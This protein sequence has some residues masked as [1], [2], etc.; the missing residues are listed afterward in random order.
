MPIIRSAKKR[1][2]QEKKRA[3]INKT[4]KLNLKTLIKKTR[5]NKNAENLTAVFSALD[6]A[7]KVGLIHKN[8]SARLKSRLSKGVSQPSV[9]SNS[10]SNRLKSAKKKVVR[11]TTKKS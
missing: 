2:R 4:K 1:M 5:A 7:A 3:A 8:K 10:K 9:T 6:K 11:K